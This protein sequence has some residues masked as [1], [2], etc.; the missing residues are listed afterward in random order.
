[1]DDCIYGMEEGSPPRMR[2]KLELFGNPEPFNRITPADAGKTGYSLARRQQFQDHPRGCGENTP[3]K[4]L[5]CIT[6]RITPA[7]AGKTLSPP[8]LSALC[9]DH[10]RGCGEN[11][12][13]SRPSRDTRGSPPR[14]RGKLPFA[15]MMNRSPRITPADAGKTTQARF[16][17]A[18]GTDH[19]R[20]C[21]ENSSVPLQAQWAKGSPPRM[22]GKHSERTVNAKGFRIT[23]ADAGKT[24]TAL[25]RNRQRR[26]HPRGC[27]ENAKKESQAFSSIGS[28]PR[29]RGKP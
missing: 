11:C 25:R 24:K 8:V 19:P 7:D 16:P 3:T 14:M 15:P 18:H 27:G 2:G 4:S 17:L 28:P 20:G 9:A 10:P 22:R 5:L 6:A 13:P 12:L 23:P 26:D 1:M 21:G 29:M